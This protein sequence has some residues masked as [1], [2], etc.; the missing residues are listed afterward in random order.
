MRNFFNIGTPQVQNAQVDFSP[1]RNA[2]SDFRTAQRQNYLDQIAAN[3]RQTQAEE[4]QFNRSRTIET[5]NLA[6]IDRIAKMAVV[7]KQL[8]DPMQKQ[9]LL[10][11]ILSI[12]PNKNTLSDVYKNPETAFD[13]IAAEGA[14]YL[15]PNYAQDKALER[16]AK[17]AEIAA[18]Y[19]TANKN[20]ADINQSARFDDNYSPMQYYGMPNQG[21]P[22]QIPT[23]AQ[24]DNPDAL[25]ADV[26]NRPT[27]TTTPMTSS[28]NLIQKAKEE[29]NQLTDPS[30]RLSAFEALR[31]GDIDAYDKIMAPVRGKRMSTDAIT[32]LMT[33][34][35]ELP[36]RYGGT[37]ETAIG[38][39]QGAELDETDG[40]FSR[41]IQGLARFGG[42]IWNSTGQYNPTEVRDQIGATLRTIVSRIRTMQGLS[43]KEAD[44]NRE[45][46]N[47]IQQAGNLTQARDRYD[48]MRRL[49]DL[50]D[51]LENAYGLNLNFSVAEKDMF[52][53]DVLKER[54]RNRRQTSPMSDDGFSDG[55]VAQ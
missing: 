29:I 33:T 16:Q 47:L 10:Q 54:N 24:Y 11:Q 14:Q 6:K 51:R 20:I 23:Q 17:Q 32:G 28:Q 38:P 19:A 27:A 45:L 46:Q 22:R 49:N 18:K 50:K 31:K 5:D 44:S 13:L 15:D 2:L 37:F 39:W 3:D 1:I 35:K 52:P 7:G 40:Y 26:A 8:T 36:D 34:L 41:A 55:G 48:Y 4:R 25:A 53:A 30:A 21:A 42:E 12:H 9:A 43:S